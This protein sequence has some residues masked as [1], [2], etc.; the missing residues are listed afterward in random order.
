MLSLASMKIVL[1]PFARM[2]NLDFLYSPKFPRHLSLVRLKKSPS[3]TR[4]HLGQLFKIND[5]VQTLKKINVNITNL[6][7]FSSFFSTKDQRIVV[8]ICCNELTS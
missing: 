2:P 6:Y 3:P 1:V 5:N 4:V 8:G 7:T